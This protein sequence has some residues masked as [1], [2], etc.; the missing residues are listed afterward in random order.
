MCGA[1]MML[2]RDIVAVSP[3]NTYPR[4]HGLTPMERGYDSMPCALADLSP[5]TIMLSLK[6]RERHVKRLRAC[7]VASW[8]GLI[9]SILVMKENDDSSPIFGPRVA[10]ERKLALSAG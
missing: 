4:A 7:A 5:C 3:S 6:T 2:D 9:E 10:M 8:P 1:F